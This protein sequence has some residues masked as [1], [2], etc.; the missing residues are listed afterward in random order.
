MHRKIETWRI[1]LAV[2]VLLIGIVGY[3]VGVLLYQK[4][5]APA[6]TNVRIH[7]SEPTHL[8]MDITA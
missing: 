6:I 3:P 4:A 7:W 8:P 1:V 5:H 2:L